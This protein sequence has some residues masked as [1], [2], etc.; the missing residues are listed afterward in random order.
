[1]RGHHPFGRS[2][3]APVAG[4]VQRSRLDGRVDLAVVLNGFPRLSETFVLHELLELERHGLRL[5][6]VALRRPEET[7]R[8]EAL[9]RLQAE[10]EY[11]PD[12]ADAAPKLALRAAHA[13]LLLRRPKTYLNGLAEAIAS[14]DFSRTNLR[15]G[16]VLAHRLVRLGSPPVYV[17]FAH[18]PAT[19]ARFACLTAGL[20][21]GLSAHAK[22]IW[23]TPDRELARKVRDAAVVLTCTAE[24][25]RHLEQLSG[26]HTPVRLIY[27]GVDTGLDARRR[28]D[29]TAPPVVLTVGRLVEKKGHE[30]LLRAAAVLQERGHAFRLRIA[31]EGIEWSRLQRLVHELRLE[32]HVAFLGPLS[33]SEIEQEYTNAD[34]FALACR[35]LENGD[36]DGIPN[37]V[38]EAMARGLAIV[39]TTGT[40]VAEA[41]TDG[42]SALLAPQL[43]VEGFA[44]KLERLVLDPALRERL[45][46]RARE[47]VAERF[48]RSANLPQVIEALAAAALI[49]AARAPRGEKAGTAL[50]AVA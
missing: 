38:L 41:L 5:H 27:H 19:I 23:L 15:R 45:A 8:Q 28:G 24:G 33:E 4:G 48:D 18:K 29:S 49:P 11:L 46:S 7:V 25:R 10:V 12:L 50:E 47:R 26:G 13:A 44:D 34:I 3:E 6:V 39:S 9:D 20:P 2:A 22:D 1:M 30:T 17:H 14:P 37:V 36:R 31:G 16:V 40:G 32:E 35:Q 42:E 21:Y 43:D